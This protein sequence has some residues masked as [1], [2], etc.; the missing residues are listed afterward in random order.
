LFSKFINTARDLTSGISVLGGND[1]FLH[2]YAKCCNPIPGDPIVGFVTTVE[3]IKI[4]RRD[5]KNILALRL[6]ESARIVDVS[7]PA[8]HSADFIAGIHI[9]GE[10]RPALL[11]DVTHAISSYQNTNIRSVIVD[12]HGTLFDGK[13]ILYVKDT[14]HLARIIEKIKNV[15][16]ITTVERFSGKGD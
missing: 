15:Q 1:N 5:C 3:G 9:S 8:E 11:S 16:G 13:F 7:W 6:A 12:S 10:D 2:Q 14:D 4:H